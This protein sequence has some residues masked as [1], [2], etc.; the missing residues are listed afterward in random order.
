[1]PSPA[2]V[3][4]SLFAQRID[5]LDTVTAALGL[6]GPVVTVAHDWGGPVSLGWALRHTDQLAG[7][8]LSN[9]GVHQPEES[10]APTVIR[11]ART[12]GVLS[13]VTRNTRNFIRG[14]LFFSKPVPSPEI[15]KGYC[16]GPRMAVPADCR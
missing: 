12:P 16:S 4:A 10:S 11:A 8:V 6:T 7:V 13:V 2:E 15:R 1:M 14:G 5:D 9:T 3:T